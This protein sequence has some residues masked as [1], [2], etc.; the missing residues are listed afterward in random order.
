MGDLSWTTHRNPGYNVVMLASELASAVMTLFT[1]HGDCPVFH[2]DGGSYD[3]H[4]T[5][6][7]QSIEAVT[8]EELPGVTQYL[9]PVGDTYFLIS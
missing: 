1:T 7:V 5:T 4:G 9:V 8:Q 3:L 2:A 6:E